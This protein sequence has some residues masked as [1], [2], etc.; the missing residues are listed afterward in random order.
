MSRKDRVF[1]DINSYVVNLTSQ[2]DKIYNEIENKIDKLS[3]KQL[4]TKLLKINS[5]KE[6]VYSLYCEHEFLEDEFI[7]LKWLVKDVEDW[8]EAKN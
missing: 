4:E 7:Y 2:A 6:E 5:I 8:L 3:V 1:E